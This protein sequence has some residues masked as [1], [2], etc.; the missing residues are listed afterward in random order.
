[1]VVEHKELRDLLS[2]AL[3]EA[4]ALGEHVIAALLIDCIELMNQRQPASE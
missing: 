1:M 3:A 4:D 2:N